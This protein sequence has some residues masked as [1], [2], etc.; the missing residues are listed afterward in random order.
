M[1]IALKQ[2]GYEFVTFE[3]WCKNKRNGKIVIL[4]HDV[5]LKARN[6]LVIAK[7]E[8]DFGISASFY[9]RVVPQS[10]RPEIIKSIANLGHEIGYHYEDMSICK[11][12]LE[13]SISHFKK[14]LEY[15]RQYY[16]VQ[17]ICMH[18]SPVSKYDNRDLWQKYNYRDFNIIGE[19]YFDF[20]QSNDVIY[21]TDTARRWNGVKFNI[22]DKSMDNDGE[23]EFNKKLLVLL[24]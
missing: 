24:T 1:L 13:L 4:R 15:F 17:T 9:F 6:S 11:G 16:P 18:G 2:S 8:A 14:Q 10:N 7:I 5:D 3:E 23:I 21:F 19:P 22:R 20:L 12:N